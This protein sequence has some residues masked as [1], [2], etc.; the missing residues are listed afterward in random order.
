MQKS[1]KYHVAA[2]SSLV[3]GRFQ[4]VGLSDLSH[5]GALRFEPGRVS[6]HDCHDGFVQWMALENSLA[7]VC[8]GYPLVN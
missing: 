5:P 6:C 2:Y 7:W 3:L 1:G 4:L 8:T